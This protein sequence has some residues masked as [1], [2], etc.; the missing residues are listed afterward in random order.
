M[1]TLNNYILEKLILKKNQ[2]YRCFNDLLELMIS[3]SRNLEIISDKIENW[4]EENKYIFPEEFSI[5]VMYKTVGIGIR[6]KDY[7]KGINTG[8]NS[9]FRFFLSDDSQDAKLFLNVFLPD[10][11]LFN[12]DVLDFFGSEAN[13]FKYVDEFT[14]TNNF[15]R[16]REESGYIGFEFKN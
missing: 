7:P 8:L 11:T 15:K 9:P 10:N 16:V 5:C 2:N 1:K 13:F 3:S 4:Y 12:K 14:K 6:Y